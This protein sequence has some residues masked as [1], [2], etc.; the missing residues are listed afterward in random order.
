M[1]PPFLSII[2]PAYNE[3][4]RLPRTLEQTIEYLEDQDY[5]ADIWVVDNASTDATPE[6]IAEFSRRWSHLHGI[7]EIRPGKGA[8]VRRGMLAARGKFRFMC[9]ADLSMPIQEVARFLPPQRE[10]VE[11]AIGSREAPGAVRYH[12]PAYRHWGGRGINWI[13]QL[14]ALPGLDD[15]QC[16]FKCFS[17]PVAEYLFSRQTLEGW[18]FDIEILYLA[19]LFGYRIEEVPIQWYFNSES[20]VNALQDAVKMIGDLLQIRK[21]H[22]EGVYDRPH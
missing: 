5:Q 9:D 1:A 14:L 3:E 17:G 21:N 10:N 2:I 15:T 7:Q 6:I 18:S 22:R 16:G 11:V 12:E 8:A 13:I 4:Y 20:K 19:R